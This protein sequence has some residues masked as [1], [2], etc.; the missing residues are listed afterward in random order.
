MFVIFRI[1]KC[2]FFRQRYIPME[3][4]NR[5]SK[6]LEQLIAT[7]EVKHSILAQT[8]RFDVSYISKWVS[9]RVLPSEKTAAETLQK[10]CQC[11]LEN[12]SEN[13]LATLQKDYQIDM[14]ED[15]QQAV[16]DSLIAEYYYVQ[17]L[18]QNSGNIV[19]P[20]LAYFPEIS[21]KK[22]LSKMHHPVLR[23]VKSLNIMAAMDLFYMDSEYRLQIV[24]LA[25]DQPGMQ[26]SFPDVHFSMLINLEKAHQNIIENTLFITS[27]LVNL[28]N[29]DFQLYQGDFAHGKAM[30]VVRDDFCISGVLVRRD[31]CASVAVCEGAEY[32]LPLYNDI[33][34]FCTRD[35]LLFRKLEMTDLLNDSMDYVHALLAPERCWMLSQATEILLPDDLFE[36]LLDDPVFAAKGYSRAHL[37]HV[38]QLAKAVLQS[39]DVRLLVSDTAISNLVVNGEVDFFNTN[40]HINYRQRTSAMKYFHQLMN[41]PGSTRVKIIREP[42]VS[43]FQ[44]K[45]KPTMLLSSSHSYLRLLT[46]NQQDNLLLRINGPEMRSIYLKFFNSVWDRSEGMMDTYD[47]INSF[48]THH[49]QSL[50]MLARIQDNSADSTFVDPRPA[51]ADAD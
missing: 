23:R 37:Q 4:K 48:L 27:M 38:H 46:A 6:L 15:L 50:Q 10:L 44:Y 12:A 34:S 25:D 28:A 17:E 51:Y 42:L 20:K 8:L 41:T 2:R 39:G 45:T 3:Q 31:T 47:E 5:F 16:Y 1:R 14:L 21:M 13:G 26:Y 36:E 33:Q 24:S 32:S 7:T 35:A 30:F 11:L 22:F 18:Q 29:V 19:A 43:D 9:G 40:L 49:I